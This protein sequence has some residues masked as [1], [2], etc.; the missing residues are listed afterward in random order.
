MELK[1]IHSII[2]QLINLFDNKNDN[3]SYFLKLQIE[4]KNQF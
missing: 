3:Y 2:N 4:K 1:I